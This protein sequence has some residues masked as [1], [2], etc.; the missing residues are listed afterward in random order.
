MSHCLPMNSHGINDMNEATN[1]DRKVKTDIYH[2]P[3]GMGFDKILMPCEAFA[4][5]QTTSGLQLMARV[6][7]LAASRQAGVA[8]FDR[9]SMPV[10]AED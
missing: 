7:I 1:S 9:V 6:G 3:L 8:A 10:A 2:A 5:R 4:H